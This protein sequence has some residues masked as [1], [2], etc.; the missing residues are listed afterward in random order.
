LRPGSVA[1]PRREASRPHRRALRWQRRHHLRE[2]AWPAR[3]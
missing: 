3:H 2:R 1:T